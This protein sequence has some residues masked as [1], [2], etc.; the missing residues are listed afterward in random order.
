MTILTCDARISAAHHVLPRSSALTA[1]CESGAT[2]LACALRHAL[3]E[4]RAAYRVIVGQHSQRTK[5]RCYCRKPDVILWKAWA[6]VPTSGDSIHRSFSQ[7]T[8][9]HQNRTTSVGRA[10]LDCTVG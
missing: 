4:E 7:L 2:L 1:P 6:V 9:G 10:R 8:W 3:F 5:C